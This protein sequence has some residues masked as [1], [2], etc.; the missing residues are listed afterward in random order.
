MKP[1]ASIQGQYE[2]KRSSEL[3]LYLKSFS[4][5]RLLNLVLSLFMNKST[6]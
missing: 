4:K 1:I 2:I 5:K 6:K 3:F